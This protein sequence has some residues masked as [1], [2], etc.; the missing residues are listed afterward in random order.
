MEGAEKIIKY[1]GFGVFVWMIASFIGCMVAP[2]IPG[3][4]EMWTNS[5]L[6]SATASLFAAPGLLFAFMDPSHKRNRQPRRVEQ[7]ESFDRETFE[8]PKD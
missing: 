1:A 4:P 6:W 7:V 2:W 8:I 5:L 3:G